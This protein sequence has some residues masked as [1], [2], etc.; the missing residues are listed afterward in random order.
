MQLASLGHTV[1]I[2]ALPLALT[3]LNAGWPRIGQIGLA[4][5]FDQHPHWR[6]GAAPRYVAMAE[7][8]ARQPGATL[9]QV[10][11]SAAQLRRDAARLFERI[12][13]IAMPSAAAMPWPADETHPPTIAGQPVGPRGHAIFTGWVNAAGLPGL[14]L[15]VEPA[16]GLPIGL[17]LIGP[18]GSDAALLALGAAVERQSAQPWIGPPL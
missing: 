4:W 9:W 11:E 18:Y 17:Q 8:G 14:T 13:L 6:D 1:E 2:G 3:A 5:L 16:G 15:P 12:D 7:E 10:L